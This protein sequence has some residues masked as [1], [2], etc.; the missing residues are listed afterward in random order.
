ML[1]SYLNLKKGETST[2]AGKSLTHNPVVLPKESKLLM[3]AAG[4]ETPS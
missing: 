4:A 3:A 2:I 1:L